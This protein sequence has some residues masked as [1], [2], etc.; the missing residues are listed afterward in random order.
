MS[1]IIRINGFLYCKDQ[2]VPIL[3]KSTGSYITKIKGVL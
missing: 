1:Y 3:Q 2:R